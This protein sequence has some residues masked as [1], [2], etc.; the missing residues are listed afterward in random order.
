MHQTSYSSYVS[1]QRP[2]M[3][4]HLKNSQLVLLLPS[5]S[6]SPPLLLR[7][8]DKLLI[9]FNLNVMVREPIRAFL[10]QFACDLNT[11]QLRKRRQWY[12]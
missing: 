2:D 11:C 3:T 1:I 6:R 8:E 9:D 7:L 10:F 4:L 5:K 12:H